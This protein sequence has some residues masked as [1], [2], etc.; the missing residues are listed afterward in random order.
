M[1]ENDGSNDPLKKFG[2]FGFDAY[3]PDQVAERVLEIGVKKT[4]FPAYKT[5][6]LGLMGG[7]FISF[8]AMYELFILSHPDIGDGSSALIS[9]LFYAMG[10]I[11]AFI[12]GAEIFTTNN[13]SAMALAAG[14]LSFA[15]IAKKWAI[16]FAANLFGS[17][18]IVVLFYLSGVAII[19]D[20]ALIDA[21]KIS[22][23]NKI[24]YTPLQSVIIGIFGNMLICSGL[25]MAMAGRSVIDRYFVLILPIA[26]VPA[27]N[28]QHNTGNM[29]P[30][31]LSLM[32]GS[33]NTDLA[34]EITIWAISSNL[35]FVSLGNMIGGG[36]LISVMYYYI[37]IKHS[38][39]P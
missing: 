23:S 25:W 34:A 38:T 32:P 24:A 29:F 19:F 18:S 3:E 16:V 22:T 15:Q 21:A 7:G 6:L 12:S 10:Y 33:G 30:F 20:G 37:Y 17:L 13:L 28:F 5:F 9:P 11:I 1:T 8:G 27:M 39:T 36:I 2:P 35:F 26:A 4:L 31:F 14:N